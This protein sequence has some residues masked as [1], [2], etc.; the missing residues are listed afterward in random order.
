MALFTL[1]FTTSQTWAKL[2]VFLG[3]HR[4]TVGLLSL[5]Y[6]WDHSLVT[7]L[8]VP[9]S[10]CV[11][12]CLTGSVPLTLLFLC[13][14]AG[15]CRAEWREHIKPRKPGSFLRQLQLLPQPVL[16]SEQQ[17]QVLFVCLLLMTKHRLC[18]FRSSSRTRVLHVESK[19]LN[20]AFKSRGSLW[21]H[22]LNSVYTC[23]FVLFLGRDLKSSSYPKG[24][25]GSPRSMV[26]QTYTGASRVLLKAV[27]A[28]GALRFRVPHLLP[29]QRDL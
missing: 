15:G 28:A 1:H 7:S 18:F 13:S 3:L 14:A 24:C 8:F 20:R 2:H 12:V 9:L 27:S 26:P 23:I 29:L 11:S 19:G 6:P 4:H 22:K 5:N 10:P 16:H 21:D 17:N 25:L